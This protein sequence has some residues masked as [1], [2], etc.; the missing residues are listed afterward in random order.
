MHFLVVDDDLWSRDGMLRTLGEFYP[1]AMLHQARS[2]AEATHILEQVPQ[3]EL[4]LLDLNLEDC[5]GMETLIQVKEW[6]ETHEMT[7]RIVIV[8]AAADFDK[9]V[10]V[11]AIDNCATGFITKGTPPAVFKAAV[12]LTMA[13][14]VYI[15]DRYLSLN[16]SKPALAGDPIT[17][18]NR[19]KEVAA[20]LLVGRSYKEIARKLARPSIDMSENT[21]RVHVQRMAWKLK[22]AD[23]ALKGLTAKSTVLTAFADDRWKAHL[24][25]LAKRP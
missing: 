12:D 20:L 5:K 18:T 21:V 25:Q 8:S 16:R 9:G 13:G 2:V 3:V 10:L 4:V 22:A 17:F 19:E 23:E 15:T 14:R 6:C 24:P 7:P 11:E 1:Q